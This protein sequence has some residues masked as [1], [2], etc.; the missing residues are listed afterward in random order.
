MLVISGLFLTYLYHAKHQ[1][2]DTGNIFADATDNSG[3]TTTISFGMCGGGGWNN[4]VADGDTFYLNGQPVRIAD[5]D[6]PETHPS[7]CAYEADLGARATSRLYDLLNAGPFEMKSLLTRD[8]DK[9]GRKLRIIT[10][11]GQS[12]GDTLVSEGL[13]RQWTGHRRPWCS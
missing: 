13:A 8:V 2:G 3:E 11:D 6:A 12:L 4:C 10:R 1:A 5:I 9:Y 7:R